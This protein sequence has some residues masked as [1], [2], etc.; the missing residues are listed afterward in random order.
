MIE[1]PPTALC[2]LAFCTFILGLFVSDILIK[3]IVRIG[4][5]RITY[6][7]GCKKC[8]RESGCYVVKDAECISCIF[9]ESDRL[10]RETR[11]LFDEALKESER[12]KKEDDE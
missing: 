6:E 9:N 4:N 1:V 12:I 8:E 2:M 3:L 11:K 10:M 7:P 5:M